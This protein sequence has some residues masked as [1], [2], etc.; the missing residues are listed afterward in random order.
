VEREK[1]D[2][3]CRDNDGVTNIEDEMVEIGLNSKCGFKFEFRRLKIK[4]E[5]VLVR[6]ETEHEML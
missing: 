1:T 2:F 6:L 5:T 4:G 3:E